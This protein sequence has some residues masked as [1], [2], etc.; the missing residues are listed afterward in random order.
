MSNLLYYRNEEKASKETIIYLSNPN[1]L[2]FLLFNRCWTDNSEFGYSVKERIDF[3][4]RK[5]E[6]KESI[7]KNG[8]LACYTPITLYD[9]KDKLFV[10]DGQAR[11]A[12]ITELNEEEENKNTIF[13]P[14]FVRT[15]DNFD[16]ILEHIKVLRKFETPHEKEKDTIKLEGKRYYK[17][18]KFEKEESKLNCHCFISNEED[19]IFLPWFEELFKKLSNNSRWTKKQLEN[20]T[21]DRYSNC[22]KKFFIIGKNLCEN[23]EELFSKFRDSIEFGF[24]R[25][26]RDEN[27]CFSN[28]DNL[29]VLFLSYMK[30]YLNNKRVFNKRK[31]FFDLYGNL[32]KALSNIYR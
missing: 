2:H 25:E 12:A 1:K 3:L 28:M 26:V 23:D 32:H 11:L 31:E 7:R 24:M 30:D 8:Y 21:K 13:V 19:K 10:I 9:Y 15:I 22:L 29:R 5:N 16:M 14:C 6:L 18:D 20:I 4:K 17:K 27:K